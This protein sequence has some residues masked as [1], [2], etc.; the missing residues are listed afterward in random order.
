M[1]CGSPI[2]IAAL[3]GYYAEEGLKVNLVSGTTFEAQQA[4]L[5]AGKMPVIN[6]DYQ[7][8]PAINS[9]FDIKLISGLH[10]GCIKVLVPID[11][12]IKSAADLKG[13]SVIVDA[14]D[15]SPMMV[16]SVA[17]GNAGL[18]PGIGGDITW[19]PFPWDQLIQAMDK[20]EGDVV[21]LWEPFATMAEKSGRYRVLIDITKD[22]IFANRNCC[23]IFA[24]GKL[25]KDNPE[26]VAKILRAIQKGIEWV[27]KH[28]HETA[29]LLIEKKKI[30]SDDVD[31]VSDL[32]ESY[33]YGAYYGRASIIAAKLDAEYFT[34]ELK[35]YGFLPVDLDVEKF[36]DNTFV[37]IFSPAAKKTK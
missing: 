35:K 31:F 14:I 11:S 32:L 7:F 25:I 18:N 12:P 19:K 8:F 6:G 33:N 15:G 30:A 5:A 23:F 27:S 21:A 3:K 29:E 4:A 13:K 10:E 36:V 9:G 37:D 26:D 22:P 34:A 24:S 2:A 16:A 17:A 20:G 28:P 1:S